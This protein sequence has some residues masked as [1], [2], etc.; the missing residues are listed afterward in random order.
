[1]CYVTYPTLQFENGSATYTCDLSKYG[2]QVI[3]VSV[4]GLATQSVYAVTN[5][6]GN[7]NSCRIVINNLS[8][9]NATGTNDK[10]S[11]MFFIVG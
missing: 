4:C 1:M 8:N 11:L 7:T 10:V 6:I 2:I 3:H 5:T 9:P